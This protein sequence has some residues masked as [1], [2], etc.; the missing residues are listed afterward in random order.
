[1]KK[2]KKLVL[3]KEMQQFSGVESLIENYKRLGLNTNPDVI[4]ISK[5]IAE[6]AF[7][8]YCVYWKQPNDDKDSL[9]HFRCWWHE[10]DK[11]FH[12]FPNGDGFEY[13]M[14]RYYFESDKFKEKI[15]GLVS[16]NLAGIA[17]KYKQK[18]Q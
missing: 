3:P 6:L 18:N 2:P 9:L 17:A 8:N 12:V 13:F 15:N 11:H 5:E 1:M 14:Q 10:I 16:T 7:S 4:P